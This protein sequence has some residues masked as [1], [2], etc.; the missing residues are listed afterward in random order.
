MTRTLEVRESTYAALVEAARAEGVSLDEWL[1]ARASERVAR[2]AV[3]PEVRDKL[4]RHVVSLGHATGL[5][6]QQIDADLAHAYADTHEPPREP[7]G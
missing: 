2:E 6:N 4:W 5:D 7:A 3:T 1:A